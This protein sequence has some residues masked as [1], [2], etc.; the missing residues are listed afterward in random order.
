[1]GTLLPTPI[2]A[3]SSFVG[4][5]AIISRVLATAPTLRN[6]LAKA[7]A[8]LPAPINPILRLLAMTVTAQKT[9]A[10]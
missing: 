8:M 2:L 4:A 7:V 3:V 10:A 1:M 5:A 9:E 6:P